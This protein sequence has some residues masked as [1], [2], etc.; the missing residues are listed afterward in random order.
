MA[1]EVFLATGNPAKAMEFRELLHE[2]S[3]KLV[4]REDLGVTS[5]A[6]EF[7]SSFAANA[8]LKANHGAKQS[9]LPTIADDS[10]LEVAALGGRPGVYSARYPGEGDKGRIHNILLELEGVPWAERRARFVCVLA[11]SLPQGLVALCY[12]ECLGL[13]TLEPRGEGGFGYDPIFYLPEMG[14]TLA[15]M[16][17]EVKNRYSHRGTAARRLVPILRHIL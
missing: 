9:G 6:T 10:G 11:L 14:K 1:S 17:V 13:I 7:A 15:E 8:R 16:P 5:G 4:T 12:G 2:I 3:C